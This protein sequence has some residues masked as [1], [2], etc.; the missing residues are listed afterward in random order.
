MTTSFDLE[1]Q[2]RISDLIASGEISVSETH[3][4][5]LEIAE[6]ILEIPKRYKSIFDHPHAHTIDV[7]RSKDLLS[8]RA[9]ILVDRIGIDYERIEYVYIGIQLTECVYNIKSGIIRVI[10]ILEDIPQDNFFF[11]KSFKFFFSINFDNSL[12][13]IS[14]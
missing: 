13:Y 10:E 1:L 8:Q 6:N 3:F 2:D 12:T 7:D 11:S 5:T 9:D 4:Q 14:L